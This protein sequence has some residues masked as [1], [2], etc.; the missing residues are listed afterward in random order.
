MSARLQSRFAWF[1]PALLFSSA[2]YLYFNLFAFPNIPFLLSGDQVY[3]WMNAQRM[4]QG[5]RIYQDF[6]QFTPPGA[7]LLY[8]GLFKL[9]LL[10]IWV[11]NAAVLL[12]G[13]ISCWVCYE[14]SKLIMGRSQASLASS[15]FLVLIYGKV[16][17]GTHHWFSVLTGMAAV[18]ILMKATT[19]ARIAIAGSLLGLASFFTQTRGLLTAL[20]VAAYLVRKS[21]GARESWPHLL[22]R[23]ALLFLPFLAALGILSGYFIATMG[24]MQLWYFQIIYV[25][26]FMVS[27][28]STASLGLPETLTWRSLPA[29]GQYLV[30]YAL[31][32]VVYGI[33]LWR[34]RRECRS[35]PSPHTDRV[36]L[37][38]LVGLAMLLEIALSINWLRLFCVAM[39]GIILLVWILGRSNVRG[40]AIGL[41]WVG[42]LC[43]ACLQTWARQHREF[44]IADLPAGKAAVSP[45][46]HK[47]LQWLLQNTKPGDLFFQAGWPGLYLPL[48]LHNPV[49]LDALDTGDQTRPQYLDLSIRQLQARQV[50]FILWSPR[51]N[52]PESFRP[53]G[54]YHLAPFLQFLHSHYQRLEVF[55]D[56]DEIWERK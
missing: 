11:T 13:V 39:P 45:Q 48:A 46:A 40:H 9:F 55:S 25:K 28:F 12:L 17:N 29:L 8:L 30:V 7:D 26:Q 51:L 50:R 20:A 41:M 14:I 44:V 16:L 34:C 5:E 23:Q 53:I 32:P 38:T 24:I 42:V 22:R 49:Y 15:F 33:A 43:L 4:L 56:L 19:P 52:F 47:K 2:I 21:H 6:F 35:V 37:L 27:G 10:H 36:L 31:L 54:A 1:T 18:E 3:F